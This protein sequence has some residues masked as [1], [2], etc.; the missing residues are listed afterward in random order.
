MRVKSNENIDEVTILRNICRDKKLGAYKYPPKVRPIRKNSRLLEV[1]EPALYRIIDVKCILDVAIGEQEINNL[2]HKLNKE[3]DDKL[4]IKKQENTSDN[5][6]K[7]VDDL[8]KPFDIF[9]S[10]RVNK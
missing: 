2:I 8:L 1:I 7:K 6:N 4:K 3:T 10:K 5:A 9:W